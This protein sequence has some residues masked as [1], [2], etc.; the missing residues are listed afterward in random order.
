MDPHTIDIE[1]IELKKCYPHTNFND[2]NEYDLDIESCDLSEIDVDSMNY[3]DE[4]E[5]CCICLNT[6]NSNERS[7]NSNERSLNSNER[8]LYLEYITLD[9]CKK[10]L[11]KQCLISWICYG[12]YVELNCPMCREEMSNIKDIVSYMDIMNNVNGNISNNTLFILERYYNNDEDYRRRPISVRHRE[13]Y[14][15]LMDRT[16]I[17][18]ILIWL[19]VLTSSLIMLIIINRN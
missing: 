4:N 10:N 2:T 12:N 15:V 16:L 1:Q 3:F 18:S 9:C 5:E 13:N 14:F 19:I 17:L 7:L 6:L 8:S 11:H